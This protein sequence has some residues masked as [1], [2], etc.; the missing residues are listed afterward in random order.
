MDPRLAQLAVAQAR[1]GVIFIKPL[2][3]AGGRFHIPF[4]N[5]KAKTCS[6][7]S[8]KLGFAGAR[9]ALD[10]QRTLER[11]RG[12]HRHRQIGRRDIGLGRG[13]L[14]LPSF[15]EIPANLASARGLRK[16]PGKVTEWAS[17][18]RAIILYADR[19]DRDTGTR[20]P[21]ER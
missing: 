3:G 4:Q 12:I 14:H 10:Q 1:D 16:P 6:N 18:K 11:D 9:L 2:L 19:K 17:D 13:K 20:L 7:L 8:G 5:R 15:A 21:E